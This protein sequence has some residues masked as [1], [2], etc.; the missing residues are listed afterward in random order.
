MQ[1]TGEISLPIITTISNI[2]NAE[3]ESGFTRKFALFQ[4]S[5]ELVDM[6]IAQYPTPSFNIIDS[7]SGRFLSALGEVFSGTVVNVG[8]A[9]VFRVFLEH[10]TEPS[11]N[12]IYIEGSVGPVGSGADIEMNTNSFQAQGTVLMQNVR[13]RMPLQRTV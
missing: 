8:T 7:N 12:R 6:G 10:D 9:N 4:D 3:P 11:Y 1:I 13:L 2:I 5:T